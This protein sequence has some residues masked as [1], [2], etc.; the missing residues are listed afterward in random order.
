MTSSYE[1]PV[2]CLLVPVAACFYG[3]K[4][5]LKAGSAAGAIAGG[6]LGFVL[7]RGMAVPFGVPRELL[8]LMMSGMGFMIGLAP[9]GKTKAVSTRSS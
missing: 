1:L 7:F 5:F 9:I 2:S 4:R 8:T 3:D 6:L